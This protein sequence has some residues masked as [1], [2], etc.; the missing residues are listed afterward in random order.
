VWLLLEE[1]LL[2]P[3]QADQLQLEITSQWAQ[4]A[5][6]SVWQQLG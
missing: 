2:E 4:A 1:Q 6:Q 3:A 5:K